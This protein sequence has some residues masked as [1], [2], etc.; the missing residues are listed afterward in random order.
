M[1]PKA[2]N[3][4]Q[5]YRN[6][7]FT[8][9]GQLE[10]EGGA[11]PDLRIDQTKVE[12]YIYQ[13]EVGTAAHDTPNPGDGRHHWQGYMELITEDASDRKPLAYVKEVLG[14]N[15]AHIEERIGSQALAIK[16][17]SKE[18]TRLP[19]TAPIQWGTPRSSKQGRRTDLL[20]VIADVKD[21]MAL[22][23]IRLKHAEQVSRS[24]QW[25]NAIVADHIRLSAPINRD[26]VVTVYWGPP[27]VG[28]TRRVYH[29]AGGDPYQ[30]AIPSD[31]H[32]IWWD[33]YET[34]D[35]ILIDDFYGWISYP[36]MLH[37]LDRWKY[38]LEVKGSTTYPYWTKVYIT[39]NKP[40]EEWW[41]NTDVGALWRRLNGGI[42]HMVQDWVPPVAAPVP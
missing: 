3:A 24:F 7:I 18:T 8:V 6:V 34:Q 38:R 13:H 12:F 20:E 26:I 29:E 11:L 36:L 19:G 25:T 33:G 27:G 30:V 40:P 35:A 37:L 28:K 14:D 9:H 2:V 16:Y 15:R 32:K 1:P 10:S 22:S 41:P 23:T 31:P 17:C 4:R 5:R 21:G 42:H 39:S